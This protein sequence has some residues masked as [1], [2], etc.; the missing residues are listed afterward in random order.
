[1]VVV[2]VVA[3]AIGAGAVVTTVV[4]LSKFSV[5]SAGVTAAAAAGAAFVGSRGSFVGRCGFAS[6]GSDATF[7]F[8]GGSVSFCL[9][10][11]SSPESDFPE[12]DA[13]FPFSAFALFFLRM[14]SAYVGFLPLAS[15]KTNEKLLLWLLS[16]CKYRWRQIFRKIFLC[17]F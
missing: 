1:M 5:F 4:G 16:W 11:V 14:I 12:S 9:A 10:L 6:P 8:G 15:A 2:G 7:A 3:A 17:K 13:A